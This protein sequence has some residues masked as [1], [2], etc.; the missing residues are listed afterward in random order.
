MEKERQKNAQLEQKLQSKTEAGGLTMEINKEMKKKVFDCARHDLFRTWKFI[1]DEDLRKASEEVLELL[2]YGDKYVGTEREIWINSYSKDVSAGISSWRSYSQQQLRADVIAKLNDTD[3]PQQVPENDLLLKC[4]L[5]TI[6]VNDKVEYEAM[7][8]W[9]DVVLPKVAGVAGWTES[10]RRYKCISQARCPATGKTLF[11]CSTEAWGY[12][13]FENCRP[14]WVASAKWIA[15]PANRGKKF[16]KRN[17]QNGHEAIHYAKYSCPDGGVKGGDEGYTGWNDDGLEH[18]NEVQ[19]QIYD[20]R[21]NHK[22]D[23]KAVELA[24]L[25][26]WKAELGLTEDSHEAAKKKKKKGKDANGK[27][28]KRTKVIRHDDE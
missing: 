10:T 13:L 17:K 14:K 7:K 6:D 1:D 12:I 23:Y 19:K 11:T 8:F 27:T 25:T 2:G 21:R 20:R 16:P 15:D 26:K 3:D 24:F 5:R 28:K 22:D 18:F 4:A 9:W